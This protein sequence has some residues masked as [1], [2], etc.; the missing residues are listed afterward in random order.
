VT[1]IDYE[2]DKW[3]IVVEG[4][5]LGTPSTRCRSEFSHCCTNCNYSKNS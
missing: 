3:Y 4:R 5:T 1:N 2:Y